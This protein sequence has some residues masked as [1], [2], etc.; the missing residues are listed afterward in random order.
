MKI[1]N[2]FLWA[3][4]VLW[5][6]VLL[7]VFQLQPLNAQTIP[8]PNFDFCEGVPTESNIAELNRYLAYTHGPV[9]HLRYTNKKE[10][11]IPTTVDFDTTLD[12]MDNW[13]NASSPDH[14]VTSPTVY[15]A[16]L[17][18]ETKFVIT[19]SLFYPRDY[20]NDNSGD[21]FHIGEHE[22]DL[23]RIVLLIDR[24]SGDAAALVTHHSS[25]SQDLCI[26]DKVSELGANTLSGIQPGMHL[27]VYVSEGSHAIWFSN[28]EAQCD[29]TTI[30]GFGVCV[31]FCTNYKGTDIYYPVPNPTMS[32]SA[33]YELIDI[34]DP[35]I[36]VWGLRNNN[37]ALF[38]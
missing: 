23:E 3:R 38:D 24:C 9:L 22:N 5:I 27:N 16:V 30:L 11:D 10:Y 31:G 32:T 26:D 13:E 14:E 17:W 25:S 36:G 37:T 18:T 8:T 2:V 19:Y 15:Y 21:C 33:S 35:S 7:F 4:C 28:Q 1:V 34:F 20:K 29:K 12:A 6:G